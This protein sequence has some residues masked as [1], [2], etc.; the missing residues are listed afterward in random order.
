M[1]TAAGSQHNLE[2]ILLKKKNKLLH[3]FKQIKI[4]YPKNPIVLIYGN[5]DTG[6]TDF[7]L[8]ISEILLENR[9]IHKVGTN[10]KTYNAN[11]FRILKNTLELKEFL[12]E[13]GR[14][15]F[16]LDE[17]GI[18]LYGRDAMKKLNK[19]IVKTA[20]LCRKFKTCIHFIL[21]DPNVID[22]HILKS[23]L[24][25]CAIEKVDKKNAI[26]YSNVKQEIYVLNNIPRTS[27]NFDTYDI[28]SFEFFSEEEEQKQSIR[29]RIDEE[30]INTLK[31]W[32]QCGFN[33]SKL[34]EALELKYTYEAKRKVQ[35]AIK[36]ILKILS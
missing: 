23:P 15:L 29:Q 28:A 34:K 14:K 5:P 21:Q 24:I 31:L 4:Y 35:R 33:Y 6:K 30:A 11:N 3:F 13:P 26:F 8:L 27:I 9:I 2:S 18:H 36:N 22:K 1:K 19:Y 16:C 7:S 32:Q 25:N 10:I 17:A 20:F 12:N